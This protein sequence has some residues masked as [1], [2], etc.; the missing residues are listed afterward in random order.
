M[1][2]SL[3]FE[4]VNLDD[5]AVPLSDDDGLMFDNDCSGMTGSDGCAGCARM[6]GGYLMGNSVRT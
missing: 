2:F 4:L 3:F 6:T 1:T 5:L